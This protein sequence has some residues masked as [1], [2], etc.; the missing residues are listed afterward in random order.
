VSD[1]GLLRSSRQTETDKDIEIIV[2]RHQVRILERQLN[3]RVAY[4]PVD[5][6]ILA[7]LYRLLPR[8]RCFSP[9]EPSIAPIPT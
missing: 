3:A 2:L 1:S 7:A 6:T 4:R 9:Q 8:W 5:R